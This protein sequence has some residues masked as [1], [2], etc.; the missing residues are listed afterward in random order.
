MV[1]ADP[2][3]SFGFTGFK[4][5]QDSTRVSGQTLAALNLMCVAPRLNKQ[6]FGFA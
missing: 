6:M 4:V 5:G 2:T 1:S 3:F